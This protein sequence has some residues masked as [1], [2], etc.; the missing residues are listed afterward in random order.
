MHQ[1]FERV[2]LF[3]LNMNPLCSVSLFWLFC[4]LIF[5]PYRKTTSAIIR[6]TRTLVRKLFV[7]KRYLR[8]RTIL[9]F[10]ECYG[11]KNTSTDAARAVMITAMKYCEPLEFECLFRCDEPEK[12]NKL[13]NLKLCR[14]S[15]A[16]YGDLM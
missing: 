7:K 3:D 13:M 14:S 11:S 9:Q 12:Q 5:V 6:Y 8:G 10:I 1:I 16:I 15:L 2:T 4:L